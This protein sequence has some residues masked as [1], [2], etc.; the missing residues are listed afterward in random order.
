MLLPSINVGG[1]HS[2]DNDMMGEEKPER[3]FE[4][5]RERERE[6]ERERI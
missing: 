6:R 4:N 5:L 2:T 1:H 3:E